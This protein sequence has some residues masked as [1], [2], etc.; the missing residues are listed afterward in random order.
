MPNPYVE[1][2]LNSSSMLV[3]YETIEL[4]HPNFTKA[5]RVVRNKT[6]GLIAR[7]ETGEIVTFDYY[8]LK[9]EQ[10]QTKDD[11][12]YS[13][14]VTFGDVGDILPSELDAVRAASGFQTRPSLKYRT[15]RSDDLLTIPMFGPIT[16]EITDIAFSKTGVTFQA[17]APTLITNTTGEKYVVSRFPML[18]T[19]I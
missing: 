5:Y 7:L 17:K 18:K 4:S 19:L 1:F 12:D 9:L 10:G 2:F 13:L 8:P 16:L 3:Q 11:L 15:Y 14:N 6:D